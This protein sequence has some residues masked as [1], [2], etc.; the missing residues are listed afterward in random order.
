MKRSKI[1]LLIYLTP[2]AVAFLFVPAQSAATQA[3]NEA[4]LWHYS[5]CLSDKQAGVQFDVGLHSAYLDLFVFEDRLAFCR[6]GAIAPPGLDEFELALPLTQ[7]KLYKVRHICA[8]GELSTH[9][10]AKICCVDP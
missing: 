1:M 6:Q 4:D 5:W 2:P 9:Q 8:K 7:V 3:T 10:S